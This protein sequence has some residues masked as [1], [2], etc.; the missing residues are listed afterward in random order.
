MVS[1][2]FSVKLIFILSL[3]LVQVSYGQTVTLPVKTISAPE[4]KSM[5]ASAEEVLL[6]DVRTPEEFAKSHI[7][8]AVNLDFYAPDFKAKLLQLKQQNKILIYCKSGRR[9]AL[10]GQILAENSQAEVYNLDGGIMKWTEL[11]LPV[12]PPAKN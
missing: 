9:S 5:L 2:R 3:L 10:A 4:L 1:I 7:A 6:L 8:G 12:E 11:N